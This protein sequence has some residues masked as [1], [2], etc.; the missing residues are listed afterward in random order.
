MVFSTAKLTRN[1]DDAMARYSKYDFFHSV[2]YNNGSR[3]FCDEDFIL[4]RQP[5]EFLELATSR[6]PKRDQHNPEFAKQQRHTQVGSQ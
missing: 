1:I 2:P 5:K 3:R 6:G 4:E